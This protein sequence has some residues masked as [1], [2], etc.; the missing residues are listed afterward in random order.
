MRDVFIGRQAIY[1]PD[2]TVYGYELLFRAADRHVAEVRDGDAATSQ[3]LLQALT[4]F[5][6]DELVGPRPAFVNVTEHFLRDPG[7]LPLSPE[8]LILE[9]LEGTEPSD[10][11]ITRIRALKERGFRIALDDYVHHPRLAPLVE[12][13]DFIKVELPYY[14]EASLTRTVETLSRTD[15]K[16][17]AEKV[18]TRAVFERCR[19][20]GFD[21][22]Q[23]YFLSRPENVQARDL[24]TSRPPLLRLLTQLQQ[25]EESAA[26]LERIINRD[27][28][29]SY[30]LL[31]YL[32]SPHFPV[33]RNID[34]IQRAII[35]LGTA[36]LRRWATLM[37]LAS[38][39]D[40]PRELLVTLMIRARLA[41]RLADSLPRV[42]TASAFMIGLFS[43]LDVLLDLPM[44]N[45]L[46]QL[47]L[48][49]T[50]L[51]ALRRHEGPEG[52]LLSAVLDFERGDAGAL[53]RLGIEPETA[54]KAYVDAIAWGESV[55][56]EW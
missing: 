33:R 24:S 1:N 10:E 27:P 53:G 36:E 48:S 17:L 25:E 31:R 32:N 41:E 42:D 2:C 34:S 56:A 18:E 54:N 43:G 9:V 45:L 6:L 55:R 35:Y 52:E 47:P 29:L 39:P 51:A 50:V 22:F 15:A 14:D 11:V 16:L 23:G 13:A 8:R 4:V 3:V 37:L 44:E 46:A 28:A 12:L 26:G 49:D 40:R 7:D 30:K 21:L 19:A 20:L 5:G 38:V